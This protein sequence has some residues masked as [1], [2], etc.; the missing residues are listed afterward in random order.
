MND[1]GAQGILPVLHSRAETQRLYD[2]IS[3]AGLLEGTFEARLIRDGL[4]LLATE[5]GEA[6][7][8]V[9]PGPG[10]ALVPLAQTVG[11]A[12]RVCGVDLSRG[13]IEVARR[14]L[15]RT[16]LA[17][18]VALLWGDALALPLRGGAFDG[19]FMSFVLESFDT[20]EIP[21]VLAE[22]RRVLRPGGRLGLVSLSRRGPSVVRRV[23]EGL[24]ARWPRVVDSRP[25]RPALS[26]DE[27]G[28]D[29]T[30]G[31]DRRL[32]G[33]PVDVLLARTPA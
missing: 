25:I 17:D 10:R 13:M 16:G 11:R 26:L 23:Y 27:A 20:P 29:V 3:R 9:G 32:F 12:G 1:P 24:H 19:A 31:R 30:R 6:V 18:R 7:L 21:S 4:E 28:F 8:E 22:V 33:L 2:R 14:R 15:Q 5:E